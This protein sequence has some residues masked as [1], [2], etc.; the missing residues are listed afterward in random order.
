MS[1]SLDSD[2]NRHNAG[3][4]LDP[5][6]LVRLTADDA[7]KESVTVNPEIFAR[8]LFSRIALNNIFATLKIRG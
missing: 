3:P 2:Q 1:N 7:S 5:N 4:D 8:I 6:S